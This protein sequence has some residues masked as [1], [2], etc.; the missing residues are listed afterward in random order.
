MFFSFEVIDN[1]HSYLCMWDVFVYDI[2]GQYWKYYFVNITVKTEALSKSV[3]SDDIL[4]KLSFKV[5]VSL[6]PTYKKYN[7]LSSLEG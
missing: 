1:V 2:F 7:T 6:Y 3:Y 5:G 4:E